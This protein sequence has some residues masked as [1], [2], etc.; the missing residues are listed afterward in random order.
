M[1]SLFKSLILLI[2]PFSVDCLGHNCDSVK[3]LFKQDGCC[4]A[5]GTT[6]LTPK[7]K[8]D[9]KILVIFEI[10]VNNNQVANALYPALNAGWIAG[11]YDPKGEYTIAYTTE[12]DCELCIL[13]GTNIHF[14]NNMD[15]FEE[16][17]KGLENLDSTTIGTFCEAFHWPE[18]RIIGP[19]VGSDSIR[20]KWH[21]YTRNWAAVCPK[22]THPAMHWGG[23]VFF[24]T[25][26][27]QTVLPPNMF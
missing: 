21:H 6:T 11:Q 12:P 16:W 2:L 18:V 7:N 27:N 14:L 17:M 19:G 1:R 10:I 20:Q 5:S 23:T 4:S 25:P 26:Q 3:D 24:G 8:M 9:E 22:E 13:K 15:S